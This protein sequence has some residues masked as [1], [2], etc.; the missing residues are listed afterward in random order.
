MSMEL[1]SKNTAGIVSAL[2]RQPHWD[3]AEM[4]E[5]IKTALFQIRESAGSQEEYLESL[6][7][8]VTFQYANT[9]TA[10]SFLTQCIEEEK[11][12]SHD[13]FQSIMVNV[14]RQVED[15]NFI[16]E[17]MPRFRE[18]IYKGSTSQERVTHA[19]GF[20]IH[21]KL[22]NDIMVEFIVAFL[23]PNNREFMVNFLEYS[24]GVVIDTVM[25]YC[26]TFSNHILDELTTVK[27]T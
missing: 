16:E 18:L 13:S 20:F 14:P 25:H 9:N 11:F 21:T 26:E 1:L 24:S 8:N 10:I 17:N 5:R 19:E 27:S 22:V 2:I 4:H 3:K 12:L 23:Q 6:L 7:R 15:S